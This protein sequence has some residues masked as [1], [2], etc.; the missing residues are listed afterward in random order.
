MRTPTI[1]RIVQRRE[2]VSHPTLFDL[3]PMRTFEERECRE[4]GHLW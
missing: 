3:R 2:V 4:T 1:K